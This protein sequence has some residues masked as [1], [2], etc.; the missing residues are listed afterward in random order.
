MLHILESFKVR[1]VTIKNRLVM[2]PMCM[3]SAD[4]SGFVEDFH[5]VHYASRGVGGVGTIFVEATAVLPEGRISVNDLGIWN[6]EHIK[7]HTKLAK[8]IEESG[9]TPA[10]QLAHAGR[11]SETKGKIYGPSS[12][13]YSDE[14]KEPIA[15]TKNDIKDV[16]SAFKNGF[17][18]AKK[19]GYK[20]IEIHAAHGYL[21]NEFLSPLTNKR[22]DEYGSQT[23][24]NRFRIVREIISEIR[25][26]DD[27][28]PLAIRFSATDYVDGGNTIKDTIIFSK[29]AKDAGVDL[30]DVS[31]GGVSVEQKLKA[32]PGYQA[33]FAKE[34]RKEVDIPTI[35]VGMISTLEQAEHLLA[36][37]YADLVAMGRN[38]LRD[39]YFLINR[40]KAYDKELAKK[41]YPKQYLRS[42]ELI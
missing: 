39:P 33:G 32:Y 10:I 8:I 16:I 1:E 5:L 4:E 42:F 7:G 37:N 3:Y 36:E 34:I 13:K 15:M 41:Y 14:Y 19:S 27:K 17:I 2:P 25:N 28:T 9:A 21:L 6:D 29:M 11:K 23:Y 26:L 31:S 35:A 18:R 38:L 30:I 24:E 12:L 20:L 22:D 40:I